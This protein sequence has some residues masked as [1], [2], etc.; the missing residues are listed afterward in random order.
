[1]S[2]SDDVMQSLTYRIRDLNNNIHVLKELKEEMKRAN[3]LKV[4]ELGLQ[5]GA[6]S[7]EEAKKALESMKPE[8]QKTKGF[9]RN[10]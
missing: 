7:T 8:P 1:M 5:T 4:L 10:K 9:W 6:Y 3:D 2:Y